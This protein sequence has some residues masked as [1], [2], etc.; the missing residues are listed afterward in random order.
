MDR[1]AK[2]LAGACHIQN[3]ILDLECQSDSRSCLLNLCCL[4]FI[5]SAKDGTCHHGSLDQRRS[6]VLVDIIQ[7][8]SGYLLAV[9]LDIHALSS[10]HSIKPCLI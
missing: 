5:R 7:H 8:L 2:L 10:E 3:V 4:F 1:F 6:L 9:I